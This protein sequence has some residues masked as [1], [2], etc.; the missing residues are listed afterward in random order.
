MERCEKL[1][2]IVVPVRPKC[3][4]TCSRPKP[5]NA[6]GTAIIS[7]Q[8]LLM[9]SRVKLVCYYQEPPEI[10]VAELFYYRVLGD[11]LG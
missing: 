6:P 4:I 7:G 3:F 9:L 5:F 11:P 10:I 2:V 8:A 1:N